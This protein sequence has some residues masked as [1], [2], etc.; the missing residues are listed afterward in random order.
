MSGP[1]LAAGD[2]TR[3]DLALA[4][5]V[6]LAS[7]AFAASGGVTG[8]F[9]GVAFALAWLLAGTPY[10][11]VVGQVGLVVLLDGGPTSTPVVQALVVIPVLFDAA[12]GPGVPGTVFEVS[13]GAVVTLGLLAI[14]IGLTGTGLVGAIILAVPAAIA[15]G[16]HRY[17]RLTLGLIGDPT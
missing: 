13:I 14:T 17:E 15:Y 7:V 9:I 5:L 3:R 2:W 8:G 11:L 6:G 16:I 4:A 12:K 1:L 10:A